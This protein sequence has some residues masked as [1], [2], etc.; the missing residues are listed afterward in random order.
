MFEPDLLP[1]TST[2][3][4]DRE[5]RSSDFGRMI[6]RI[7]GAVATPRSADE[8]SAIVRRAA[9]NEIP[10]VVR[11]AGHSQGGQS[12]SDGGLVLDM[13]RL[14]RVQPVGGE[15]VRAQ[16]GAPWGRVVD[17]LH[18]TGRLPRVLVD[19]A[20]A[21]VGGTLS[22]GGL[23]TTSH[24]YGMQV[25]QVEELEAVTGTGER[26]RCSRRENADLFHA[27]R[28][29]QGQF[30]VITAAWIRLRAAGRRIRLYE[31][32]Y[33]DPDRFASDFEQFVEED[34]FDHLRV[35]T[36]VHDG[37]TILEA[38]VEYGEELDDGAALAGL[39]YDKVRSIRD[40]D[41]V[42]R[43]G[44]W[45]K[46]GF[47]R[48]NHHPWRDWFLPWETLRTLLG[49]PWLDPRW[50]PRAPF[51]WVGI[52]PIRTGAIDAPLFMRP[53]GERM[54]SY[55][56]MAVLGRYQRAARLAGRLKEIDRALVELGAKSY[57][58]GH[59]GYGPKEWEEHYGERLGDGKRWKRKFDPKRVF[60]GQGMPF[61]DNPDSAL[62]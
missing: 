52:Y 7:P 45:P 51:T 60:R 46:W 2:N 50:L 23:G 49:H 40:T 11:G 38:G 6:R 28:A 61:G 1:S 10:L 13:A 41:E 19:T 32:S 18:G 29:G 34:R 53:K 22:A 43:A 30:G 31:L 24:R 5:A 12:L 8:L 56:I 14:S 33:A 42:G 62:R 59:V 36:R 9:A 39:G 37:E 35:E 25:G 44:M 20:E 21:T 54:I 58:S 16:G 15:M 55:S 4:E 26:V 57:L 48:T 17:A 3:P 27:V 47:T